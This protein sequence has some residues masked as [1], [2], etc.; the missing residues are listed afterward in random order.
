MC[1]GENMLACV[2]DRKP[3]VGE[4]KRASE[5][6]TKAMRYLSRMISLLVLLSLLL[7]LLLLRL[8]HCC[9]IVI[10]GQDGRK[11]IVSAMQ[12]LPRASRGRVDLGSLGCVNSRELVVRTFDPLRPE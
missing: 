6:R 7:L 4:G 1:C 8:L 3:E 11:G 5:A 12:G 10:V 2:R 9:D